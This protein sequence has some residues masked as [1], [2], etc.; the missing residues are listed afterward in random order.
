MKKI[1]KAEYEHQEMLRFYAM[2]TN[3]TFDELRN[4]LECLSTVTAKKLWAE[5]QTEKETL[6]YDTLKKYVKKEFRT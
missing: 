2:S 4:N 3:Q 6:D 5:W 1:T